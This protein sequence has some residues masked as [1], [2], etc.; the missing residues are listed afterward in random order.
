MLH[1]EKKRVEFIDYTVCNQLCYLFTVLIFG[2]FIVWT[3]IP[4]NALNESYLKT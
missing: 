2:V 3:I 4:K 1:Y